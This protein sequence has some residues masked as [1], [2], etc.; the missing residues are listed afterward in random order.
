MRQHIDT[1]PHP[2]HPLP[3]LEKARRTPVESLMHHA[4][5][6]AR[7]RWNLSMMLVV[8]LDEMVLD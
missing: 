4:K 7:Q 1:T 8:L 2:P 5:Q 6:E 3:T